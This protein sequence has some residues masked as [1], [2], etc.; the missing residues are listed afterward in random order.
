MYGRMMI[1]VVRLSMWLYMCSYFMKHCSWFNVLIHR[2]NS[3]V[4]LALLLSYSLLWCFTIYRNTHVDESI[5]RPPLFFIINSTCVQPPPN[6]NIYIHLNVIIDFFPFKYSAFLCMCVCVSMSVR[7]CVWTDMCELSMEAES[8]RHTASGRVAIV[9]VSGIMD[10]STRIHTN[11]QTYIQRQRRY[12][13]TH[14]II[15]KYT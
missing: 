3:L 6:A 12:T 9:L 4:F 7:M 10:K 2:Q 14:T 15:N 13:E 1:A 11:K 8:K 5:L